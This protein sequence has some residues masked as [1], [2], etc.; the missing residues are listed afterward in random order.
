VT[1]RRAALFALLATE[2]AGAQSWRTLEVSRQLRDSAEHRVKV[3][4]AVGRLRLEP[5]ADPV[6]FSMQLRYDEERM[7][8][9]HEYTPASR[10]LVLGVDAEG[11]RWGRIRRD[12]DYGE[13]RLVLSD[14]VPMDLELK[15][16]A[17]EARVDAGGLALTRLGIETGAA[18]AVLDFSKPNRAEMRRLDLKLGAASFVITN[19]GNA[20]VSAVTVEGGVGSV[21]LD[22]G[23]AIQRDVSVDAN[24]AL[25]KLTL[26]LPRDVGVRVEV[27]LHAELVQTTD[28]PDVGV[29]VLAIG[30]VLAVERGPVQHRSL[31]DHGSSCTMPVDQR[32]SRVGA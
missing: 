1:L 29:I 8:P 2:A 10:R 12:R 7:R 30:D 11:T 3:Q 16:G 26:H 32:S 5:S 21:D 19:L 17:A 13:M 15:L 9:V 31:V 14:A 20:N 25:G 23:G 6:L 22:F 27:L 18:D 28:H 24:V 4:Y